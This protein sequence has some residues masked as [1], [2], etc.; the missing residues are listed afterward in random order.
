MA[1]TLNHNYYRV[2]PF[3]LHF[4]ACVIYKRPSGAIWN[5]LLQLHE[6]HELFLVPQH[7]F[8]CLFELT[9][10]LLNPLGCLR[11]CV[12]HSAF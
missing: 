11:W 5:V 12:L 8:L 4:V 2:S 9:L 3:K 6:F 1:S 7:L 10:R